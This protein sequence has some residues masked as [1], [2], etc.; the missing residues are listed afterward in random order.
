MIALPVAILDTT[1]FSS[2]LLIIIPGIKERNRKNNVF[3]RILIVI[4]RYFLIFIELLHYSHVRKLKDL[5][6]G[7][8]PTFLVFPIRGLKAHPSWARSCS[9][10]LCPKPMP[11]PLQTLRFPKKA[12]M[13]K[14]GTGPKK[15]QNTETLKL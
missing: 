5:T 11:N 4:L 15:Q 8:S 13:V 2:T 12:T 1:F 6:I 10:P 3:F 9:R 14:L 7:Q